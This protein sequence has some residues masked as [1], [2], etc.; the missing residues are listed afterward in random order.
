[1][2]GLF[3]YDGFIV[4]L[5]NKIVDCICLS[6]LWLVTSLPIVTL[7]ASTTALYYA[8]NVGIRYDKGGIWQAYWRSFR[9]N[10]KQATVLWALL[11]LI[12]GLLC[13]SCYS[14]YKLCINGLLF[15][16]M[17][18]FLLIVLALVMAWGNMLFP[19]LAKFQNSTKMILKNCFGIGLLNLPIAL[20]QPVFF[21]LVIIGISLFPPAIL[22]APGVYMV[23]SCYTL[24][25][26]FRKYMSEED[27]AREDA[28]L[29]DLKS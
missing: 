11:F 26:V 15:K 3:N 22:C 7:G 27:R 1:M 24:E 12:Y 25:P 18:Y 14:A 6:F 20:L 28:L 29:Q 5:C 4:Q 19:Y 2:H 16:E 21:V 23:L 17:F 13:G 10:F 8:I 9:S